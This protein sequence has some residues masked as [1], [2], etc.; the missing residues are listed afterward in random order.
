MIAF[1]FTMFIENTLLASVSISGLKSGGFWFYEISVLVIWGGF[2]FGLM[3]MILYY[4]FFHIRF[5]KQSLIGVNFEYLH[6]AGNSHSNCNPGGGQDHSLDRMQRAQSSAPVSADAAAG[7]SSSSMAVL[8]S[9]SCPERMKLNDGRA[10]RISDPGSSS[11]PPLRLPSSSSVAAAGGSP[12]AGMTG[13]PG[14]FNCRLNPALKRKKKKPSSFIPPPPAATTRSKNTSSMTTAASAST[15]GPGNQSTS[16]PCRVNGQQNEHHD[17]H[18]H[19]SGRTGRKWETGEGNAVILSQVQVSTAGNAAAM[20]LMAENR[21]NATSSNCSIGLQQ[22]SAASAKSPILMTHSSASNS[23]LISARKNIPEPGSKLTAAAA[24]AGAKHHHTMSMMRA[25]QHQD[26]EE[27][28]D[29]HRRHPHSSSSLLLLSGT[30]SPDVTFDESSSNNNIIT[31][32]LVTSSAATTSPLSAT[33]HPCLPAHQPPGLRVDHS[34]ARLRDNSDKSRGDMVSI[35]SC[36]SYRVANVCN[37]GTWSGSRVTG[38]RN[39]RPRGAGAASATLFGR[40]DPQFGTRSGN[41]DDDVTPA[42]G[43][44]LPKARKFGSVQAINQIRSA[45]GTFSPS[46]SPVC[47]HPNNCSPGSSRHMTSGGV[48]LQQPMPVRLHQSVNHQKMLP[49]D[50]S[51]SSTCLLL[52]PHQHPESACYRQCSQQQQ[53][54]NRLPATSSVRQGTSAVG[55]HSNSDARHESVEQENSIHARDTRHH[56]DDHYGQKNGDQNYSHAG[57]DVPDVGSSCR[58]AGVISD[59]DNMNTGSDEAN[60][61]NSTSGCNWNRNR[62]PAAGMTDAADASAGSASHSHPTPAPRHRFSVS[63]SNVTSQCTTGISNKKMHQ[64]EVHVNNYG[65]STT[66]S[67]TGSSVNIQQKLREKREQQMMHLRHIEQEQI[68]QQVKLWGPSG[69]GGKQ[70]LTLD[71]DE[72]PA[73][74]SS[75]RNNENNP[76]T[77][78]SASSLRKPPPPSKRPPIHLPF[79]RSAT[80]ATIDVQNRMNQR[81]ASGGAMSV[82]AVSSCSRLPDNSSHASGRHSTSNHY[83]YYHPSAR[84]RQRLKYRSQTPE[85]MMMRS[86]PHFPDAAGRIYYD[87]PGCIISSPPPLPPSS[88]GSIAAAVSA[89]CLTSHSVA[90]PRE[91]VTVSSSSSSSDDD[92]D[93]EDD[94]NRSSHQHHHYHGTEQFYDRHFHPVWKQHQ[95][96]HRTHHYSKIKLS[97]SKPRALNSNVPNGHSGSNSSAPPAIPSLL[98][99]VTTFAA[100]VTPTP[101]SATPAMAD[102]TSIASHNVSAASLSCKSVNGPVTLTAPRATHAAAV[103]VVPAAAAVANVTSPSDNES[104]CSVPDKNCNN[105]ISGSTSPTDTSL[106]KQ[107]KNYKGSLLVPSCKRSRKPIRLANFDMTCPATTGI[108]NNNSSSDADIDSDLN[109][110]D[111]EKQQQQ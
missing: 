55:C 95:N 73:I 53:H 47:H 70:L 97:H 76:T 98:P 41:Q 86:S 10:G 38:R 14:V 71:H 60:A 110:D 19:G 44:P 13:I 33:L 69:G 89:G 74:L 43:I 75:L 94:L 34:G 105:N 29:V 52:V 20:I 30:T 67:R 90:F 102:I 77:K 66:G 100:T 82:P 103:V 26:E 51:S 50:S 111:D 12:S 15:T 40:N 11:S 42:A 2:A 1:Y 5:V 80:A 88:T 3:A 108:S 37:H 39:E 17:N 46:A 36:T 84:H 96:H 99:D 27:E 6:P 78:S 54:P 61:T 72:P 92:E 79:F 24:A 93:D 16:A 28:E 83:Q 22:A 64:Q 4:K 87:Y 21:T 101:A 57:S 109:V 91:N 49:G 48:V 25:S 106:L 56:H 65:S 18:D 81:I 7:A 31:D 23:L 68:K 9:A 63:T 107:F 59:S 45:A 62:M 104:Q 58:N 32:G 8:E 35:P 85:V